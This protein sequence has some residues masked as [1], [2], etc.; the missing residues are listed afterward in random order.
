MSDD[1]SHRRRSILRTAVGV[2]GGAVVGFGLF[3]NA[4]DPIV[5]QESV[6]GR[7]LRDT[8]FQFG[9]YNRGARGHVLVSAKVLNSDVPEQVLN[10][11]SEEIH[12]GKN[13]RRVMTLSMNVPEGAEDFE[14]SATPTDFPGN[15][16]Y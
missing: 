1:S 2:V 14:I 16:F 13:E 6:N 3:V 10:S 8:Q 4:T 7:L 11:V 15:L 12:M 9:V 5:G